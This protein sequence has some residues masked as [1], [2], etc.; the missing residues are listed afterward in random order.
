MATSHH[1]IPPSVWLRRRKRKSSM[2]LVAGSGNETHDEKE[3]KVKCRYCECAEWP[4]CSLNEEA[5]ENCIDG[6]EGFHKKILPSGE[7]EADTPEWWVRC[8]KCDQWIR[9]PEEEEPHECENDDAAE[10]DAGP[11]TVPAET[12]AGPGTAVPPE[13]DAGPSTAVPAETDAGPS[14]A[15]PAEADAGPSTAAGPELE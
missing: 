2:E 9:P 12:D 1:S 13:T 15:A 11:S 6:A 8:G 14:T 7:G 4:D 10:T 3:P 5:C